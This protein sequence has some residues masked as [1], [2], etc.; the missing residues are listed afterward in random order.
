MFP[1]LFQGLDISE[2]HCETCELAKHTCVSFPIINKRSS[3]PFH[4]IHSDVWGPSTIPNVFEAR[5]FVSCTRVTWIFLLKQKFDVRILIVN[6]HSMVQNQFRF[7]IKSFRI[8][9]VRDYFY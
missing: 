1:Y 4:L 8:D 7:Q 5:W 2:F 3:H 6:F 9:N